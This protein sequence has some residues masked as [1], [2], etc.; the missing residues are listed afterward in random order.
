MAKLQEELKQTKAFA[1]ARLEANLA[2]QRT[3]DLISRPMERVFSKHGLTPEQFNVL[4]ILRGSEPEGRPTLEIGRRMITRASNVTRIVDRLESK[5]LV[6]RRRSGDDRRVVT[7]RISPAGL[8]LINKIYPAVVQATDNAM[9]GQTEADAQKLNALLEKLR[10]GLER[11]RIVRMP[12]KDVLPPSARPA[13][14]ER[15]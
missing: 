11:Q 8:Q 1:S 12:P 13:P 14:A 6:A 15:P 7:V 5:G 3:T 4:R 2:L 10:E 9:S